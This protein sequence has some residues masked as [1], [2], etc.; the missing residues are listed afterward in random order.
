MTARH[1][2]A[3]ATLTLSA[4]G[5]PSLW[6]QSQSQPTITG[7]A[8][9]TDYSQESPGV[10][11]KIT[12]ADLPAPYATQSVDNGPKLVPKPADAWPKA[13]AGFK[14]EQYA[15]GMD[16]PRLIRFAPNGDLFVADSEIDR[17]PDTGKIRVFRGV[18]GSGKP[19]E[20]AIWTEEFLAG[21][22]GMACSF[23][24]LFRVILNRERATV[25]T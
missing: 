3:V 16:E 20:V 10:R 5:S 22:L 13:P 4:I 15:T 2:L 14:V 1:C 17:K 25:K 9:F 7:N 18:D 19:K 11:R 24:R 21:D 6:G 23:W 12:V 8:A